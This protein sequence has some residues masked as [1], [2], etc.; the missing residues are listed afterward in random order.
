MP[1]ADDPTP[2]VPPLP[3]HPLPT[4]PEPTLAY[5][6]VRED[7]KGGTKRFLLQMLGGFAVAVV[8]CGACFAGLFGVGAA[9]SNGGPSSPSRPHVALAWLSL[10]VVTAV[11]VALVWWAIRAHRRRARTGFFVGMLIGVGL[12]LLPLGLCYAIIGEEAMSR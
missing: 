4:G 12:C 1:T 6:D 3:V 7:R 8:I 10:V 11:L 9:F 5:R 2:Q